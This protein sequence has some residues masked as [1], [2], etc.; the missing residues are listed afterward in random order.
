MFSLLVIFHIAIII[1]CHYITIGCYYYCHYV[2]ILPFTID[3]HYHYAKMFIRHYYFILL[4]L[5]LLLF[6]CHYYAIIT[7]HYWW[8]D[9]YLFVD[10]ACYGEHCRWALSLLRHRCYEHCHYLLLRC[11]MMVNII[12][13]R[14]ARSRWMK[15]S[16]TVNTAGAFTCHY[17]VII[18]ATLFHAY[19]ACRLLV[20]SYYYHYRIRHTP[21][22]S[23]HV[24]LLLSLSHY[25]S[26]TMLGLVTL[27]LAN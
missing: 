3:Y 11:Y 8:H 5:L 9:E 20:T 13:Y 27:M 10:A 6:R 24:T 22:T 18:H 4:S 2:I 19:H 25:V 21:N 16:A 23:P 26:H 15:A 7:Y 14:G 17:A 1:R 12:R